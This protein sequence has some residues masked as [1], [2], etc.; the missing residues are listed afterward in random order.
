MLSRF[1]LVVIMRDE[2]DREK[3]ADLAK[4]IIES[5]VRAAGGAQA[6]EGAGRGFGGAGPA[7]VPVGSSLGAESGGW[8][9]GGADAG[10]YSPNIDESLSIPA[11]IGYL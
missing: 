10:G 11:V 8:S 3:D 5:H 4:F 1:D 9:Q 7:G 6:A 2:V